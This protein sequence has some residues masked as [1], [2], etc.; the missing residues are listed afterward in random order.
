[1]AWSTSRAEGAVRAAPFPPG[2]AARRLPQRQWRTRGVSVGDGDKFRADLTGESS[3]AIV[4]RAFAQYFTLQ[5]QT[6]GNLR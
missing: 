5:P 2:D 6:P 1:M 4:N 3:A